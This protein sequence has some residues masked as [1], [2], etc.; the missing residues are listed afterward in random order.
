MNVKHPPESLERSADFPASSS[1][2]CSLELASP[3]GTLLH[4]SV[5]NAENPVA[6]LL[7][8]HGM[9][10]HARWFEVS[11]TLN[12]LSN[13]GIT[14]L[15]Y[16]RRGSG[17]SG[18]KIGHADSAE[19]MLE[20]FA[21]GLA[22]LRELL[23]KSENPDAPIHVLANC[24]GTRITLPY[25]MKEPSAFQSVILTAPATHMSSK[26]D[27]GTMQRLEILFSRR[28]RYFDTPL[29]DQYFV[30]SDP[31]LNW[32]HNDELSL[33]RVTGSFLLST[34]ALTKKMY[35][36]ARTL[37]IPLLVILGT[38]DCMV[39]NQAIRSDFVG[40]YK[41]PCRVVEYNAEHYIDFTEYQSEL[42]REVASWIISE[43]GREGIQR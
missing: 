26:A 29:Q 4:A 27:Y 41:G 9:Q 16:D 6:G 36:A 31:A 20:D 17:R 24:F 10:S 13:S 15:A 1:G 18:G 2:V 35:K 40:N 42:A 32:I 30:S 7:L 8:V 12:T 38:R 23:A 5:I 33:R 19:Q 21:T 39:N 25:L 34:N 22:G 3:D 28:N 11:G 43:S 37:S 14:C